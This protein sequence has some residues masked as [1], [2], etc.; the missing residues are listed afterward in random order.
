MKLWGGRFEKETAKILE[1]FNGS[2]TFDKRMYEED[3]TGSI[4]HSKMLAKQG[5]IEVEEQ[6][7]IEKGLLQILGE[8]KN[9]NFTFSIKVYNRLY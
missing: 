3:I 7:K 8:I 9:G 4:A 5:I 2:I 1:E 6:E